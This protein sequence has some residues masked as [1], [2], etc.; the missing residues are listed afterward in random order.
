MNVFQVND[1]TVPNMG[2][3]EMR[4][5][6]EQIDTAVYYDYLS[7]VPEPDRSREAL[8]DYLREYEFP[9]YS[10]MASILEVYQ[11]AA[12][13][14][15]AQK[16]A[17][18]NTYALYAATRN[19]LHSY[20]ISAVK[21]IEKQANEEAPA[22]GKKRAREKKNPEEE[23]KLQAQQQMTVKRAKEVAATPEKNFYAQEKFSAD[24]PFEQFT[25]VAKKGEKKRSL[26]AIR[27]Q[28]CWTTIY[29]VQNFWE[30][31]RLVE[32]LKEQG[33]ETMMI[34]KIRGNAD[35]EMLSYKVI[36]N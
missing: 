5:Y 16:N 12:Y 35:Q 7:C 32:Q 3:P 30:G 2:L 20:E 10:T 33:K 28:T 22:P 14:C 18:L 6:I 17:I 23:E 25:K 4:E 9:L 13:C 27:A 31:E 8:L 21:S 24:F 15:E 29:H 34:K 26:D 1:I 36:S 19:T 11:N